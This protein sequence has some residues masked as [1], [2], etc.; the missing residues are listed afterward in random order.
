MYM[1]H[2]HLR[3]SCRCLIFLQRVPTPFFKLFFGIVQCLRL[4]SK[5]VA[6][7]VM[8]KYGR[9]KRERKLYIFQMAWKL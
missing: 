9:N 3:L 6:V 8:A 5:L 2:F 1:L 4:A 7:E